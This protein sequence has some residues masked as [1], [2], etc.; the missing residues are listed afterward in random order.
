[1]RAVPTLRPVEITVRYRSSTTTPVSSSSSSSSAFNPRQPLLHLQPQL[2]PPPAVGPDHDSWEDQLEAELDDAAALQQ[3]QQ[4]Q[5]QQQEA[6]RNK[7]MGLVR[8]PSVH[9]GS[10]GS[11]SSSSSEQQ[12]F[13]YQPLSVATSSPSA[14]GGG[15]GFRQHHHQP[16]PSPLPTPPSAMLRAPSPDSDNETSFS[17][18]GT[19]AGAAAAAAATAARK[20]RSQSAAVAPTAPYPQQHAATPS[21]SSAT[22]ASSASSSSPAAASASSSS[23]ALSSTQPLPLAGGVVGAVAVGGVR[24]GVHALLNQSPAFGALQVGES[25]LRVWT[26]TWNLHARAFPDNLG[27]FVAAR[28]DFDLYVVGTEECENSIQASLVFPGKARWSR[29]V[30]D[31][32]GPAYVQVAQQTLGAIHVMAFVRTSLFPYV[33]HIEHGAVATGIGDIVGNKGGVAIGFDIGSTS[34]LFIN[35]HF[36]AHQGAVAQRNADYLKICTRL[37]FKAKVLLA[38]PQLTMVTDRFQRV[39]FMGD[40]NYRV[41]CAN[42]AMVDALVKHKMVEVLLANDQLLQA[43]QAHQVFRGF[44]EGEIKFMPTY[45]FDD[46]T[47]TYDTSKKRRSV[48]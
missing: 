28:E 34:F 27:D 11:S 25:C 22:S 7:E 29:C 38:H 23:A 47:D 17:P 46:G 31:L 44:I 33:H 35:A 6:R 26:G 4:Q 20:W 42:R 14:S 39:W 13:P 8:L 36:A 45:K 2:H 3:Q 1:M 10:G 41:G 18:V 40:L 48:H 30:Q 19:A 5:Q 15:A 32:L 43:R 24:G 21:A 16:L 9:S 37:L 12:R